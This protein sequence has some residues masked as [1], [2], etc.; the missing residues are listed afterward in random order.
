L[1]KLKNFFRRRKI[2]AKEIWEIALTSKFLFLYTSAT[3]LLNSHAHQGRGTTKHENNMSQRVTKGLIFALN[4][5][6]PPLGAWHHEPVGFSDLLMDI[7]RMSSHENRKDQRVALNPIFE[8]TVM[9]RQGSYVCTGQ[10]LTPRAGRPARLGR[11]PEQAF[12]RKPYVDF[13]KSFLRKLPGQLGRPYNRHP[14]RLP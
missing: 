12:R 2:T 13:K 10:T 11:A 4:R 14:V 5:H 8:L 3:Y 1:E 6:A 9:S 7:Q